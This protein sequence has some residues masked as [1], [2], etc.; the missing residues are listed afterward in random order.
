MEK[1]SMASALASWGQGMRLHN[2]KSLRFA[3]VAKKIVA[4]LKPSKTHQ[5]DQS[6]YFNLPTELLTE[7]FS[8]LS[9]FDQVIASQVCTRWRDILSSSPQYLKHR[10]ISYEDHRYWFMFGVHRFL[11]RGFESGWS[12]SALIGFEVQNGAVTGYHVSNE[13]SGPLKPKKVYE[14]ARERIIVDI[15][16]SGFLD[17]PMFSPFTVISDEIM[18]KA[19]LQTNLRLRC[20]RPR[21]IRVSTADGPSFKQLEDMKSNLS[22]NITFH[23]G[24]SLSDKH[25][26]SLHFKQ[27]LQESA[28]PK[29]IKDLTIRDLISVVTRRIIEEVSYLQ[30]DKTSPFLVEVGPRFGV[31]GFNSDAGPAGHWSLN[32]SVYHSGCKKLKSYLRK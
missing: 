13:F 17:D 26:H 22:I 30:W 11:S 6:K 2:K 8:Y 21:A 28:I 16:H 23:I 15:S 12:G 9:F 20:P 4:V 32:A 18:A 19:E 14:S 7:I 29:N 3:S 24:E 31:D 1:S 5:L 25:V 27:Y 10:Y